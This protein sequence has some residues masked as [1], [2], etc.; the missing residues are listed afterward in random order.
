MIILLSDSKLVVMNGGSRRLSGLVGGMKSVEAFSSSSS[1]SSLP[2]KLSRQ[3]R[4][5]SYDRQHHRGIRRPTGWY[6]HAATIV[7][8]KSFM[9]MSSTT[10]T[11]T[12]TTST[13]LSSS[14]SPSTTPTPPRK[15]VNKPFDYHEIIEIRIDSLTNMGWGIGR[16]TIE[17]DENDDITDENEEKNGDPKTQRQWVV[18]VP[19]V[20][21]GELVRVRIYKNMKNFSEA[22]LLEVL[23]PSTDRVEPVCS[24]AGICG[25]CQYQHASIDFQR[26]WKQRHVEEVLVQQQIE[27]YHS[28]DLLNV[29]PTVGTEEVF[30]YRS[31]ITPHYQAP[32]EEFTDI[33]SVDN[34]VGDV[35]YHLDAVGFQQSSSRRLVDVPECPIATPA[36][37]DKYRETRQQLHEDAKLGLLNIPKKKKKRKRRGSKNGALGATL[38]FRQADDD[39]TTN[40]PVVVTDNNEYMTTTVKDVT[41]KYQAGNFFQNNNFMLPLM[42]DAVV[43]AATADA[44]VSTSTTTSDGD[45]QQQSQHQKSKIRYLIDCYCGSG[46]FALSAA[47]HFDLC[48]G[49]EVNEKAVEEATENAHSNGISNCQ[50][51]AA[52]AEAI[53]T[54]PPE[55]TIEGFQNLKVQDFPRDETVVVVDPPRKGCSN[56][57]LEQLYEYSPQRI[58]Y[59]SCGPATQARDAK[60]IVEIGGYT[61]TSIQPFDLFPQT[62]HIESLIVFEK[63]PE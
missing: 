11:A 37:N 46:L 5:V 21:V 56:Q 44:V 32:R 63:K 19:H 43:D 48:V 3:S 10:A 6:H 16:V 54:S 33:E 50:F 17:D 2:T 40:Q 34:T 59:M 39:A 24:L 61:M 35:T 47:S 20:L 25:G 53:F 60:G 7:A 58:V 36:I 31:K 26:K 55:L 29:L 45:Q 8:P 14:S 41:F 15:F 52:S 62:K 12:S 27:G 49:I 1:S 9:S 42:V 51:A 23:E 28:E 38:L 57:F 22:D 30:G 4:Q 18:M 13:S